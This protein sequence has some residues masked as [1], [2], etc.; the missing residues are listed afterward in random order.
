MGELHKHNLKNYIDS[1][2][3]TQFVETGT[4]RGEGLGFAC[5]FDFQSLF[6]IEYMPQLFEECKNKFK[7]D[8]RV[9]LFN[10][11]SLEGLKQVLNKLGPSPTLFWLDAHFPGADFHFNDY[12]HLKEDE[13]LH[14][15]LVRELQLIHSSRKGYGDVFI[16]DDLQLYE[17]GPFELYNAEFVEKYGKKDITPGT[18]LF[19][20]SHNFIRDHRHQGFLILTPKHYA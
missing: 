4:G 8:N 7:G 1:F 16:I 19:N 13:S 12:D 9:T 15:P 18:D 14:M 20:D 3:C 5:S 17:D 2:G 11:N 6:S 10:D